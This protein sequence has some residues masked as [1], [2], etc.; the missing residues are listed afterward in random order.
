MR[1]QKDDFSL[2]RNIKQFLIGKSK[3]PEDKKIFETL[4]IIVLPI[5]EE[6]NIISKTGNTSYNDIKKIF[7]GDKFYHKVIPFVLLPIKI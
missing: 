2:L 3:N 7:T 5:L 1:I 4:I 6:K